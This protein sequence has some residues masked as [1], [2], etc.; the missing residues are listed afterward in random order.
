M[1]NWLLTLAVVAILGGCASGPHWTRQLYS[2]SLAADPPATSEPTN[3]VALRKLAI[4]PR[5]QSR[6][7]TYRTGQNSY[8]QDPYA[9][10]LIQP[11]RGLAEAIR[12]SMRAGGVFGRVIEPGTGLVPT[13][14]AEVF[15]SELYGD[16]RDPAQPVGQ[17][18]LRFLCYELQD[19]TPGHIVVDKVYAR[20]TR[21]KGKTPSAL[22]AAWDADLHDIMDQINSAYAKTKSRSN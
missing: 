7:F 17:L 3:I 14:E 6:S 8:E 5:F 21:L 19:G 12:A 15:V 10:F 4:S 9:G 1:K 2:F 22:M 16:F 18:E 20:Q 11:E 13:C